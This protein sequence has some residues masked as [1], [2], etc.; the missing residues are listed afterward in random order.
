MPIYYYRLKGR[1]LV[2]STLMEWAVCFESNERRIAH[3][4][5]HVG[6]DIISVS[7]VFT[8]ITHGSSQP[9]SPQVFETMI[10]TSNDALIEGGSCQ[11]YASWDEAAAGH[12]VAKASV[13][14]A[15]Q[16]QEKR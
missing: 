11:R 15:L 7:T 16:K 3:D 10:F 2:P 8:G 6:D 9:S 4:E 14:M 13:E 1:E 12:E 5:F